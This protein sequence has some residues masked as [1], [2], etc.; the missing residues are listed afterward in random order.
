MKQHNNIAHYNIVEEV[1]PVLLPIFYITNKISSNRKFNWYYQISPVQFRKK[2]KI[3][4]KIQK[5]KK[6]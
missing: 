2:Y 5:Y 3:P 4:S 1:I 6:L